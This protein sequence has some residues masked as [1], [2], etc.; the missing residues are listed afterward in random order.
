MIDISIPGFGQLT[1]AHLLLDYNGTLAIDGV[2]I[3]GVVS[4]LSKLAEK[5]EL[6]VITGDSFGTAREQ[7]KEIKCHLTILPAEKQ[8]KAKKEYIQKFKA[9]HI[10]AIGNGRNDQPMVKEAIIGVAIAGP[11][12]AAVQTITAADIVVPSI[13]VALDLLLHP[14]RLVATLRS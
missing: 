11:E 1:L 3:E 6:H 5:L 12:G 13:I 10:M 8:M 9:E 14:R 4:R 7:L 2:L